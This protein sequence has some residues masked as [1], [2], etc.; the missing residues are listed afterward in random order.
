M[1]GMAHGSRGGIEL[2]PTREASGTA[3]VPDDTPMAGLHWTAGHWQVMVHGVVFGQLTIEPA[4]VHRTGGFGTHQVSSANWG[5]LMARRALGMGRVG[6]RTMVSAERWTVGDC[7]FIDFFATGEMCD[8]DTIHDRQH[9]HDLFMEL[10]VDY[11]RPI[12]ASVRWQIYGGLAGEPALGPPAFPHRLSAALNP[13]APIGHHWIDSTHIAFGVLTTGLETARVRIEGSI[14]NGREP[15]ERRTDL[16]LGPLD[17]YSS[18]VTYLPTPRLALQVSAGHLEQAEAQFPPDPRS[19]VERVTASATSTRPVGASGTWA[20][21]LGYGLS[22]AWI[23]TPGSGIRRWSQA[24]LIE[25]SLADG[26]RNTWFGRLE[27]VGKPGHDLHAD[28]V[29]TQLLPTSKLQGGF[30][31][32]IATRHHLAAGVGGTLAISLVPRALTARY[33]GRWAHGFGVFVAL[34]PAHRM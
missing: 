10:A 4:E 27:F 16:D 34:K 13:V 26:R 32:E 33:Y 5:M 25:S 18:R 29:A 17:S 19:D 28:A 24:L 23:L 3:W 20:T 1:P 7:G 11:Q 9:P 2:F 14:F 30:V 15:D 31:R 8:G 12:S 22:S 6:V 21:T